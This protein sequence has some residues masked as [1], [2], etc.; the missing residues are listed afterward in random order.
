MSLYFSKGLF[1]GFIFR[2]G[3][4]RG[5]GQLTIGVP[6]YTDKYRLLTYFYCLSML[7]SLILGDRKFTLE[8]HGLILGKDRL[9]LEVKLKLRIAWVIFG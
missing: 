4:G 6:N 5:W 3:W 9:I 1:G 7:T 8:F 2:W